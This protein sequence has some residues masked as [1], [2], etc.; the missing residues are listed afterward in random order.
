LSGFI[1]G[2]QEDRIGLAY[3]WLNTDS[4]FKTAAP[5]VYGYTPTGA[6]QD[7]ELYY[8]WQINKNLQLS[9]NVQWI[10]QP[11][12]DPSAQNLWVLGLRAVAGF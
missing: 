8:A 5:T 2:R 11:G 1:W 4:G 10:V 7:I 12:G 6:E 3:G 9:P